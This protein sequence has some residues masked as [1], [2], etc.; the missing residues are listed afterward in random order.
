MKQLFHTLETLEMSNL[1]TEKPYKQTGSRHI[2]TPILDLCFFRSNISR[3]RV[4]THQG[5]R[6]C[7]NAMYRTLF[8]TCGPALYAPSFSSKQK[9]PFLFCSP[10]AFHYLCPSLTIL[11]GVFS[12]PGRII[13]FYITPYFFNTN[14]NYSGGFS[15]KGN[16]P[17]V[18]SNVWLRGNGNPKYVVLMSTNL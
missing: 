2:V 1:A 9:N 7:E 4:T 3:C 6:F 17:H 11:L 5:P 13:S 18:A 12:L 15:L 14:R 16:V 10:L 8:A